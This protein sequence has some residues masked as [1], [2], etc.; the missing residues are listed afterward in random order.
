MSPDGKTLAV[1]QGGAGGQMLKQQVVLVDPVSGNAKPLG[2]PLDC[3]HLTW[4]PDGSGIILVSRKYR[5]LDETPKK[6]VC[7]MNLHGDLTELFEGNDPMSLAPRPSI[8]FLAKD[9]LWMTCDLDGKNAKQVLDGLPRCNFPAPS[10][11]G[12]EPDPGPAEP[13]PPPPPDASP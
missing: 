9:E 11:D 12:T 13:P 2:E 10:P 7:R 1:T 6:V 8:L 5:T 3:A 4:L